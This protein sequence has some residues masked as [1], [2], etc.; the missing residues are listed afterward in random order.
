LTAVLVKPDLDPHVTIAAARRALARSFRQAGLA[1]PALD[2]RALVAHVLGLDHA[3]LASQSARPLTVAQA[4]AIG[5]AAERRLGREPVARILGEKEFWGLSFKLNAATLVPRPETETVIEAALA[6]LD[7]GQA[8]AQP[9]AIADLGTGS[10]AL[11]L[12]LL[13]ELPQAR[14]IG[15]DVSTAALARARENAAALGLAGRAAFVACD[16]AAALKGP[17]DLVVSNPPYVARDAIAALAPEV[18]DFDPRV[19]LDGGCDGLAGYRAIAASARRLL[20][21]DGLLVLELGIG[22]L[23]AVEPLLAKGRL[24]IAA[25]RPDL[26]GIPRALVARPSL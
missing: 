12:A 15:S 16:F 20:A 5:S 7:R 17:F 18:R 9:L 21:P 8:R 14:G 11:L 25:A 26:A 10:G 3:A 1:T 6:A 4:Q 19:A 13:S 2:A 23:A 22:Q 24:T